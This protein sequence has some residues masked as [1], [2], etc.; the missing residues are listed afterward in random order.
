[1]H[2]A[3]KLYTV[4]RSGRGSCDQSIP[5]AS[6]NMD[7]YEVG[8]HYVCAFAQ[9]KRS[10]RSAQTYVHRLRIDIDDHQI[11]S[12]AAATSTRSLLK[13][14]LNSASWQSYSLTF[15]G[16]SNLYRSCV[17]RH[18][19]LC[20]V[21]SSPNHNPNLPTSKRTRRPRLSLPSQLFGPSTHA[22]CLPHP[23]LSSPQGQTVP[24]F[25]FICPSL[26]F[27]YIRSRNGP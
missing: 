1:M 27:P 17:D 18:V 14:C 9:L 24:S 7:L 25:S 13:S 26:T 22:A 8:G 12:I 4:S 16:R 20:H 21:L 19:H 11:G 23:I 3:D 2:R 15:S 5:Q 10:V 6:L